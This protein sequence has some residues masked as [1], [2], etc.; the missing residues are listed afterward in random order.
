MRTGDRCGY[1]KFEMRRSRVS[2]VKQELFGVPAPYG[3]ESPA[4]WV[5]RAALS[6]GVRVGELLHLFGV[7]KIVDFDMELSARKTKVIAE[8]CGVPEL[9]FNFA[10]RM[11]STLRTIDQTGTIFLLPF[12]EKTSR[13]RYCPG[14]LHE[15]RI[16][17][18]ALHWRF[19]HWRYCPIH[20]CLME[21]RCLHCGSSITLAA[22]LFYS[23]PKREGVAFLDRCLKCEKKLSSHWEK[24]QGLTDGDLLDSDAMYQLTVG[25]FVLSALYHG[26]FFMEKSEP[27]TKRRLREIL[28]LIH[29]AGA[30][31]HW[32]GIDNRELLRRRASRDG[33]FSD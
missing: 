16:K 15:Q 7:K 14:C 19:K 10:V 24:V 31:K 30:D 18:F 3:F 22:D 33:F 28:G 27:L 32:V 29:F 6:Q 12:A 13:Y 1:L 20:Q 25:R 9:T 17:H 21:D 2:E 8:T 5:S 23:G 26:H 4:S 11:F